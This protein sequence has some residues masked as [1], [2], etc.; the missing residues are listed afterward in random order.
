MGTPLPRMAKPSPSLAQERQPLDFAKNPDPYDLPEL[1]ATPRD[2]V[3][4]CSWIASTNL[5]RVARSEG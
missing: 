3:K 4:V 1:S 5:M 2:V